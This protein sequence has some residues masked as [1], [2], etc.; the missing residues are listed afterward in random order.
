MEPWCTEGGR[1]RGRQAAGTA[2][3]AATWAGQQ[4]A[5]RPPVLCSE[6]CQA[7]PSVCLNRSSSFRRPTL[8]SRQPGAASEEARRRAVTCPLSARN[9]SQQSL[10]QDWPAGVWDVG[11][12]STHPGHV[13][14]SKPL[15]LLEPQ[16]CSSGEWVSNPA[17]LSLHLWGATF[18]VNLT[19]VHLKRV[20]VNE[21]L[22]FERS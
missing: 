18:N 16:C 15:H 6:A 11:T 7:A 22:A 13:T 10:K 20:I 21:S 14:L 17:P 1:E 3:G 4:G 8:K 19:Y 12:G 9:L 5:A 2:H